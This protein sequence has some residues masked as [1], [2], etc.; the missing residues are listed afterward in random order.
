M[1]EC[2]MTFEQETGTYYIC[3]PIVLKDPNFVY[4]GEDQAY[5]QFDPI[6]VPG[7][8]QTSEA[9][10]VIAEKQYGHLFRCI[11]AHGEE[12]GYDQISILPLHDDTL[13][14]AIMSTGLEISM[15][16]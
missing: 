8:D 13:L 15:E 11:D 6:I 3:V 1:S 4:Y 10:R 9:I 5:L 2:K 12:M 16:G 7:S 14:S